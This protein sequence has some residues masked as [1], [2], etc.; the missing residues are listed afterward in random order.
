MF[1][2]NDSAKCAKKDTKKNDQIHWLTVVKFLLRYVILIALF[3][4]MWYASFRVTSKV[5]TS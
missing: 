1:S 3:K 4:L 5:I 2:Y